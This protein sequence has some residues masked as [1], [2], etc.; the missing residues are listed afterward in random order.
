MKKTLRN[1]LLAAV[2][3]VLLGAGG[4]VS[5][6]EKPGKVCGADAVQTEQ[7]LMAEWHK[8]KG[9]SGY[10]V[11]CGKKK[12]RTKKTSVEVKTTGHRSFVKIRAYKKL[13]SGKR[14]YGSYTKVPVI[15]ETRN[16]AAS[17]NVVYENMETAGGVTVNLVS[18]TEETKV[19][20]N[21]T[22]E[23]FADE[24]PEGEY[25]ICTDDT[26]VQFSEN[27]TI[28]V[29]AGRITEKTV[30]AH[31]KISYLDVVVL[32]DGE[33]DCSYF[34]IER[35]DGEVL[36]SATVSLGKGFNYPLDAELPCGTYRVRMISGYGDEEVQIVEARQNVSSAFFHVV[37]PYEKGEGDDK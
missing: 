4:S 9:A 32:C 8:V 20:A 13:R 23:A 2:I 31:Q 16:G 37:G 17:I 29:E 1:T 30:T 12:T 5:A 25:R 14:I 11:M 26:F 27:E 33:T 34:A 10:E 18:E 24:L 6:A 22:G 21:E 19:V 35:E 15:C 7:T 3:F 36:Y 28:T